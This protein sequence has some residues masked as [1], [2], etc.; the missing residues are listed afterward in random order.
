MAAAYWSSAALM[1]TPPLTYE[2]A[3]EAVE[4]FE[5]AGFNYAEAQRQTGI[6]RSTLQTRV[7]IARDQYGLGE[8][9]EA[10]DRPFVVPPLPTK[11]EPLEV[12]LERRR[13]TAARTIEAE[14]AR[15]LIP[16]KLTM[17]GPIG[18]WLC[19][20]PHLDNEG[21]DFNRLEEDLRLVA[22]KPRILAINAGDIL[23]GWIGRLEKLYASSSVKAADGWRLAEW[24]FS[25]PGINWLGLIAGNHDKWAGH[26]D[27]LKWLS[28]GRVGLYEDDVLRLALRHPNG[29]ETRVHGR[30]NF[31]GNSQ[32]ND[33]HGLKKEAM[34]G[35]RDHLLFAGHLHLGEDGGFINPDGFL[36]RLVRLSG[37]KR[38]DTYATTLQFKP[39][40]LYASAL[41][42]INP[43]EPDESGARVWIA[44]DIKTGVDYL[45]FLTRTS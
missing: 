7:A 1:P 11:D 35:W 44:P 34:I 25:Y 5:R 19:G 16:V 21:C 45:S 24:L 23:D 4:I 17:R 27:P 43:D 41:V 30:H 15:K 42:I 36:T 14:A 28:K 3:R 18:L 20:D 2:Q 13:A 37:Y 6:A 9:T 39:K 8:P 10:G 38:V 32:W 12:L 26:N 33:M 29:Q 22:G 31:K 40:P